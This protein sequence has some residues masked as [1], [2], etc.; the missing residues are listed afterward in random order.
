M[1]WLVQEFLNN[2]SNVERV[3]TALE[4]SSTAYLIV[5]L[6]K[7]YS[8]TVLHKGTRIPEDNSA[9]I[10]KKFTKNE[11]IMVYGSKQF[12]NVAQSENFKPGSFWSEDFE[13][14]VFKQKIGKELLNNEF[15]VGELSGL[16]PIWDSFFIR[17]TGNTKLFTGFTI[18]LED[19]LSWQERE[20]DVN[21]AYVGQTLMIS[22]VKEIKA[23]YRFFVVEQQIVTA[24]SY[25]VEKSTNINHKPSEELMAYTK[26]MIDLFPLSKAFVIDVAETDDGFKVIEYNNINSS[27]LY[28]C[29][30]LNIVQKINAMQL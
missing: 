6:N 30:E 22:P 19:F 12:A 23:E 13:Y 21:S 14:E 10:L 5:R 28:G 29:D 17:P 11:N 9:D 3:I 27:G 16:K 20:S 1:K 26:E 18:T 4:M 8:L 15:V 7:D 24:S 2:S 25:V